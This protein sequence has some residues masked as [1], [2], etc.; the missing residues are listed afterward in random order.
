MEHE[1]DLKEMWEIIK[2]Y[3]LLLV[4]L[5]LLTALV[6]GL[7]SFYVLTPIYESSSTIIV[8][9]KPADYDLQSA[10]ELLDNKV[11]EANRL[12]AKTYGEIARSRTVAEQVINQLSLSITPEEFNSKISVSQIEDTEIIRINATDTDPELA[13]D[14]CNITVQKFGAAIIEIK[15][16]DSVSIIDKAVVPD[17]PIKPKKMKNIMIAFVLGL[18]AAFGL[19]LLLEYLDNTISNSKEAEELLGLLVL[20]TIFDCQYDESWKGESHASIY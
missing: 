12:L 16:I 19:S 6:S 15:K 14:I 8:G 20:G 3:W 9:N 5:P 17:V 7:I 1:I 2:K 11:L 13:A 18:G 10:S 4:V